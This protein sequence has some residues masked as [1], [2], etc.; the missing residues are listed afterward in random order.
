MHSLARVLDC[1]DPSCKC[2]EWLA[3]KPTITRGVRMSPNSA[4]RPLV[5]V[6]QKKHPSI[7]AYV[8][9]CRCAKCKKLNAERVQNC[10][11]NKKRAL[12]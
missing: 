1:L 4:G 11:R 6:E 10:R 12:A 3:S 8:N 2:N 5:A 9:G 7:S